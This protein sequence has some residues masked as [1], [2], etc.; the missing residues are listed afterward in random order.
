MGG[1][2]DEAKFDRHFTRMEL[3]NKTTG[4]PGQEG[5]PQFASTEQLAIQIDSAAKVPVRACVQERRGG[6]KIPFDETQ[7]VPQGV[8]TLSLGSFAPGSYVVRV[9][10]DD[11]LVKN[12]AFAIK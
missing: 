8:G 4:Q 12:L 6:G 3:I 5:E 7:T 10:V 2:A 11:V 9:I 1:T